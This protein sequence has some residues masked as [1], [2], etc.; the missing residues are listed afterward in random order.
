MD[1]TRGTVHKSPGRR[2]R[3][4]A[5]KRRPARQVTGDGRRRWLAGWRRGLTETTVDGDL[6][7]GP[8]NARPR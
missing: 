6:Q 7:Q 5:A 1:R 3:R 2:L 8:S 4:E